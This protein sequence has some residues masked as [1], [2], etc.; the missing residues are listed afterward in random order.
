MRWEYN[1]LSYNQP[2]GTGAIPADQITSALNQLG[3]DGWE[4]VSVFPI[5]MTQGATNIVG[6]LLKRPVT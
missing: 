2:S 1:I 5:A 3:K 6:I 4:A